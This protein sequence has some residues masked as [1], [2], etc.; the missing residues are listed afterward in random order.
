[1]IMDVV[2]RIIDANS[3][4]ASEA[5]RLLEDIARFGLNSTALAEVLKSSRHR[6]RAA[7]RSSVGNAIR[8]RDI[9]G[10]VGT[11]LATPGEMS[12]PD[13]RAMA[14]AASGRLSEAL[15]CLEECFKQGHA[16]VSSC[17]E[18]LR[19]EAY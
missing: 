15:R 14:E 2:E 1:M 11:Q 12:R 19:Y 7:V 4:R 17:L 18:K 16:E 5:Y 13:L 9:G 10:D 6:L 8:S 3:N